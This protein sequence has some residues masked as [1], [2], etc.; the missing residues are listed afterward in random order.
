MLFLPFFIIFF[1]VFTV[2]AWLMLGA[3]LGLQLFGGFTVTGDQGGVAYWAHAGGFIAGVAL[4]VPLFLR[5]GG[6]RFW[7]VTHGHPPHPEATYTQTRIP[8]VTR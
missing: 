7:Q 1:K 8:R 4:C 3:W 5:R 2:P 6:T